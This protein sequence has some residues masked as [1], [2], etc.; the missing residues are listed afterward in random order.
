MSS[1]VSI[2]SITGLLSGALALAIPLLMAGLGEMFVERSGMLNMGMEGQITAGCFLSFLGAYYTG[3]LLGG[4]AIALMAGAVIGLFM[5]VLT[6]K[7]NGS[8]PIVGIVFGL[9]ATGATGFFN[10]FLFATSVVPI[11]VKTFTSIK[12]PFLSDIPIVGFL[13][14]QNIMVYLVLLLVP[15]ASFVLFRTNLG[16][17]VR[18]V[19][20]NAQAADTMGIDAIKIRYCMWILGAMMCTLAGAYLTLNIGIYT[21]G[22]SA[23][24]GFIALALVTFARWKPSLVLAGSLL[25]GF[26]NS[27]QLRIQALN[28]G[29]PYQFMVMLPYL[30]TIVVLIIG[31]KFRYVNP[32]VIGKPYVRAGKELE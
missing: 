25:F 16:L 30:L 32:A 28:I 3:S 23:N 10:R 19:G 6:L 8:S 26:A 21:D 12:I 7:M 1:F 20:G 2:E 29:I 4:L 24:R 9:F 17:K 15:L 14:N 13:F 27:L 18:A 22:M 31:A 5:G 11:K